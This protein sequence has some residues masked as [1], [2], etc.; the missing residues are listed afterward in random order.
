MSILDASASVV[1]WPP[2]RG[3]CLAGES[4]T[5]GPPLAAN[6][7]PIERA[8]ARSQNTNKAG[9]GPLIMTNTSMPKYC[10]CFTGCERSSEFTGGENANGIRSIA[11]GRS[12]QNQM[13]VLIGIC[14]LKL[15]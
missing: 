8:V 10:N 5:S 11:T 13:P 1:A 2:L 9:H 3:R 15:Q 7:V 6:E 4:L 14:R 12:K